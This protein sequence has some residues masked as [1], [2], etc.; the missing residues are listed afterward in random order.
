MSARVQYLP[1]ADDRIE[2]GV[3]QVGED[4]PGYFM[5]GDFAIPLAATLMRIMRGDAS[6]DPRLPASTLSA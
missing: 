1:E 2:T 5:R 3:L 4:W 6:A